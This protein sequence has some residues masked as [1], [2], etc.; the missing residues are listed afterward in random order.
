MA[1]QQGLSGLNNSAKALDAVGNNI[2]NSQTAGFKAATAQFADVYAA[3]LSGASSSNLIGQGAS[4]MSVA[5]LFTQGNVTSTNNPLDLAINGNG[6]L[7]FQPSFED[8]TPV[9]SRNGQLHL[10]EEGYIVN[11]MNYFLN[12][13]PATTSGNGIDSTAAVPLQLSNAQL[14]PQPTGYS[15]LTEPGTGG[16]D[17]GVNMDVRDKRA[18]FD[19]TTPA[20]GWQSLDNWQFNQ[21]NHPTPEMYNYST[22]S[23]VFDQRGEPHIMTMYFVRLP[24]AG[25]ND[26]GGDTWQTHFILD[27][28]YELRGFSD[29]TNTSNGTEGS[30]MGLPL[31]FGPN[32]Q[33]S[34]VNFKATYAFDLETGAF[35]RTGASVDLTSSPLKYFPNNADL[36]GDLF[37]FSIVLDKATQYGSSYDVNSMTQDGYAPGLL[38]G[39]SIDSD[40]QITARYSNGKTKLQGQ[41]MLTTF[42]NPNGL[43]PLGNNFWA[44]SFSSGDPLNGVPQAGSRGAIQAGAVE[45]A[46][47]DLTQELVSMIT[48]Q[49]AYQANAQTIKTQDQILQTLVN[50]R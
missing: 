16:I 42:Q 27:N 31:E 25:T 34:D 29:G 22:S 14:Q 45:D 49:R 4:I 35:D 36:N 6:F 37:P 47:V 43:I 50:L 7:R 24:D 2:A 15:N 11:S 44:Q 17:V 48:L 18:A 28:K 21:I 10:N 3:T 13:Y 19:A 20:T 46:N 26:I 39:I 12:A 9:Y 41:I 5:Q 8:Q 23:T 40:G 32:G 1:F 38:S 33:L 30:D